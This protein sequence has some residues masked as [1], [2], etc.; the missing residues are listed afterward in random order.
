MK[1]ESLQVDLKKETAEFEDNKQLELTE[2]IDM[3]NKFKNEFEKSQVLKNV[4][5]NR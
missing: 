5:F 3:Q 1:L 2:L 4:P